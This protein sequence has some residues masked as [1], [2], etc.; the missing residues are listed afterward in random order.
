MCI[1]FYFSADKSRK[2]KKIADEGSTE[3]Q[4]TDLSHSFSSDVDSKLLM[5][6]PIILPNLDLATLPTAYDSSPHQGDM[7]YIPLNPDKLL[8]SPPPY[9]RLHRTLDDNLVLPKVACIPPPAYPGSSRREMPLPSEAATIPWL[10]QFKIPAPVENLT[11]GMSTDQIVPE[12]L[13]DPSCR[14]RRWTLGR[15][16]SLEACVTPDGVCGSVHDSPTLESSGSSSSLSSTSAASESATT[17]TGL[18]VKLFQEHSYTKSTADSS[19]MATFPWQPS[20]SAPSTGDMWD[21]RLAQ[22][23]AMANWGTNCEQIL[24]M[25][26]YNTNQAEIHPQFKFQNNMAQQGICEL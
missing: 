16:G 3:P 10:D 9:C 18:K 20:M 4:S 2:S 14:A 23:P 1:F 12:P 15:M 5:N 7:D 21:W 22:T 8:L 6:N 13:S 11:A 17:P 25:F 24:G 26:T 19:H